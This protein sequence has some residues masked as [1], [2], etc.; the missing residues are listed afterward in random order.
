MNTQNLDHLG[1]EKGTYIGLMQIG[2][3]DQHPAYAFDF[4]SNMTG[5][6]DFFYGPK[7]ASAKNVDNYYV[8][9]CGGKLPHMNAQQLELETTSFYGDGALDVNEYGP[10]LIPDSSCQT[11]I[12]NHSNLRALIY[13]Q[14]VMSNRYK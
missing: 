3:W 10:Y 12:E 7:M 1:V 13:A 4:L 8:G 11:W 6:E 14:S 9:K 5:G 2:P